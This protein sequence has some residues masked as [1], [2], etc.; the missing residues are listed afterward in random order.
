M[1]GPAVDV[2]CPTCGQGLH[3]VLAPSPPTQWFP[4]PQCRTPV[5]V[6]VPRDPPPL[7]AWEVLPGLY[8]ALPAPRIPRRRRIT[9]V[10]V[11]LLVIA[12]LAAALAGVLVYD[13]WAA[14]Q[15]GSYA[16]AGTVE[17]T[18]NGYAQ[19]IAGATVVLTNDANQ[20]TRVL[21]GVGGGFSFGAVP[22]G[23]ITL[24]I[25]ASGYQ[26]VSVAT[27]ASPVYTG[28]TQGLLIDLTPGSSAN[29]T[30]VALANFPDLVQFV[31]ALGSG[32]VLFAAVA[33]VVGAAAVITSRADRP[34]LAVI[35][36]GAGV[37]SPFVVVYLS[38]TPVSAAVTGVSALMAGIGAFVVAWRAVGMAQSGPAPD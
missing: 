7:Y 9:L 21:T 12:V 16:V 13:S 24:N 8:P 35:G 3:V 22:A 4:C 10:T 15:P 27:F 38:L 17:T 28:P 5:P 20:S 18:A 31:A 37:L 11:G 26:S 25:S 30:T 6:V 14:V 34:A 29:V 32:A 23:G 1:A 19:P 2:T 36:G 33:I